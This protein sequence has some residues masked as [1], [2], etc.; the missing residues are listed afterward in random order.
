[1]EFIISIRIAFPENITAILER[2]KNRFVGEYGSSYTSAPHIT[3]Y[4]GRYIEE[5]FP[6]LIEDLRKLP[7][8]PFTISLLKPEMIVEKE[9]QRN[10]YF[11]DISNKETLRELHAKILPIAARYRSTQLRTRDQQRLDQGVYGNEERENLSRYGGARVL[12]LFEPHITLGEIGMQNPQPELSDIQ[13]NLRQIE[14]QEIGV[15]SLVVFFYK[16]ENM[17]EKAKLIEEVT[18]SF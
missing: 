11:V 13:K 14:G 4:L 1:M 3:L 5:G 10:F 9:L 6:R 16:K 17:E 18:V 2:E 7:L 8:E 15:S 12:N